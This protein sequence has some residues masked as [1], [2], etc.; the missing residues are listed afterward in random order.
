VSYAENF[1]NSM[2]VWHE[3]LAPEIERRTHVVFEDGHWVFRNGLG[4]TY[5]AH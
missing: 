4:H 3:T 5:D 1:S 2:I